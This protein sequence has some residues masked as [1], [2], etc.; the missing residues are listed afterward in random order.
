MLRRS[1]L[2]RSFVAL[3]SFL[4]SA[5]IPFLSTVVCSEMGGAAA[6]RQSPLVRTHPGLHFFVAVISRLIF[7]HQ[8]KVGADLAKKTWFEE[9]STL[10]EKGEPF[11]VRTAVYI[12]LPPNEKI[13]QVYFSVGVG[14]PILSVR[15][16][17]GIVSR[18]IGV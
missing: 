8:A 7:D 16:T 18:K 1:H 9:F 2:Q 11:E 6:K 15:E 12:Y 3:Y 14:G 5:H 17:R 13:C 4:P 10:D